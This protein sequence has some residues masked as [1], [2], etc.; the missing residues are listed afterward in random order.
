MRPEFTPEQNELR[1]AVRDFCERE[2]TMERLRTWERGQDASEVAL[3]A[4]AARL[5]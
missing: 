5:G 3:L 4:A 2:V 1:H